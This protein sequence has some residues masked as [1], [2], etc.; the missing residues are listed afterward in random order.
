MP[1]KLNRQGRQMTLRES[2][3]CIVPLKLEDQSSGS[4]PGNAGAGKAPKPVRVSIGTLSGLRAGHRVISGEHATGVEP[5]GAGGEPDALT[6]HVRFWEGP[7][8]NWTWIDLVTPPEETGGQQG[9][10]TVS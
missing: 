8:V 7:V 9:T 2:E 10:Q 3:G 4:K 6:A 1:D 5:A